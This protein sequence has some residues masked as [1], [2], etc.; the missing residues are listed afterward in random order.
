MYE[1]SVRV[2]LDGR[3]N[4]QNFQRLY[5]RL[6]MDEICHYMELDVAEN[7]AV[8]IKKHS[9]L[10]IYYSMA[11]HE[12]LVSTIVVDSVSRLLNAES[13]SYRVTGRSPARDILDSSWSEQL[14]GMTLYECV[15]HVAGR[16]GLDAKYFSA[17]GADPSSTLESFEWENE[18]PWQKLVSAAMG[19][20]FLLYSSQVGGIYLNKV[21][22]RARPEGFSLVGNKNIEEISVETSGEQQF[23]EYVLRSE[24][25]E[26]Q[27]FDYSVPK[28]A[29][30][31]I[32]TLN[33]SDST[34]SLEDLQ[35]YARVQMRRRSCEK[36]TVRLTGWGLSAEQLSGVRVMADKAYRSNAAY[37]NLSERQKAGLYGFETLWGLNYYVPIKSEKHGLDKKL[38]TCQVEYSVEGDA[39]S[40]NVQLVPREAYLAGA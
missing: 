11:G 6:S 36:V 9:R 37:Q 4:Y 20:E 32:L 15:K 30:G 10:Q 22:G 21:A 7:V 31:R 3:L 5:V 27:V 40:C 19:Q 16:F 26:A 2:E 12:R 29:R 38:L 35:R 24:A 18:S 8:Q 28:N 23:Y 39:I 34:M 33:M 14:S 1:Q 17:N 25:G 13:V